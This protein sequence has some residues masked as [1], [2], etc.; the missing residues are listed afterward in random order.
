MS[1]F[2]DLDNLSNYLNEYVLSVH[3]NKNDRIDLMIIDDL[4]NT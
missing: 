2:N 1:L 3:K 4:K